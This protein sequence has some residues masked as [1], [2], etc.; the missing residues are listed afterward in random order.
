MCDG[1]F[2]EDCPEDDEWSIGTGFKCIRNGK[3]CKLPQQLVYDA[4]QDCDKGE[5]LCFFKE[6]ANST[7][8]YFVF[9]FC[10]IFQK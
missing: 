2:D 6:K 7:E 1:N 9:L 5:D 8:K 10:I 3:I 4:V